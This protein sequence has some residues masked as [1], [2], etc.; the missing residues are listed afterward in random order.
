MTPTKQPK[1]SASAAGFHFLNLFQCCPRK[2]FIR[3]VLRI[4]PKYTSTPLIFG[5]AFHEAKATYYQTKH[6]D[7]AL[8]V[9]NNLIQSSKK[10]L[11]DPSEVNQLKNRLELMFTSWVDQYGKIDLKRFKFLC[12][13][14]EFIVPVGNTQLVMTMRPDAIVQE[15]QTKLIYILETKTSSFSIRVTADAVMTGDQATAYIWGVHKITGWNIY[16]VQPDITFWSKNSQSRSGIQNDRPSAVLRD[17]QACLRFEL[18]VAQLISEITQ[19][20]EAFKNGMNCW[21]LFPRNSH[22]CCSFSHPCEYS[23][24]CFDQLQD[25]PK[26]P[27]GFKR[28]KSRKNI[29]LNVFDSIDIL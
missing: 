6:L 10:E 12:V 17:N 4:D 21:Q 22:Y 27:D 3:F 29:L 26:V 28:I 9:G 8:S 2:F 7:E 15:K 13:E 20:V 23:K 14:K 5:S 16:G 25:N 19:K 11:F 18:G 24:I 1:R